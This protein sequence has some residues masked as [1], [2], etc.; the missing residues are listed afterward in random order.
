MWAEDSAASEV[1]KLPGRKFYDNRSVAAN[2]VKEGEG[3]HGDVAAEKG[4]VACLSK[5]VINCAYGRRLSLAAGYRNNRA[6][7]KAQ[8]NTEVCFNGAGRGK[9]FVAF[10]FNARVFDYAVGV[11]KIFNSVLAKAVGKAAEVQAF[12]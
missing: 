3:T 2:L 9:V 10:E 11:F 1:C 5:A 8:E 7:C 12:V 6:V 4:C